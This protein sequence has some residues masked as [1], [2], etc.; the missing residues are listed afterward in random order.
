MH[1]SAMM[2]RRRRAPGSGFNKGRKMSQIE[3]DARGLDCPMPL[4]KAKQALN[5][6]NRG[7]Q[8]LLS[9]T[10]PGSRRDFEVFARQR[11]HLML[12]SQQQD[13][14]LLFVLVK[15]RDFVRGQRW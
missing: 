3:V 11:G 2:C 4:L 10:D 15:V 8:L 9:C 13:E 12:S 1:Y 7:Q 14:E 5:R 6:M